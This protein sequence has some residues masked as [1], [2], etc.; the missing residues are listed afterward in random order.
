LNRCPVS[1][2]KLMFPPGASLTGSPGLRTAVARLIVEPAPEFGID[3]AAVRAGTAS[4]LGDNIPPDPFA[5]LMER[6]HFPHPRRSRGRGSSTRYSD[7][8]RPGRSVMT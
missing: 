2:S 8:I 1:I 7:L 5:Q 6:R 4:D 3:R